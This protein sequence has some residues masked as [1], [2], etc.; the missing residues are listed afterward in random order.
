MPFASQLAGGQGSG[1]STTTTTPDETTDSTPVDPLSDIADRFAEGCGPNDS[2]VCEE[3]SDRTGNETLAGAAEWL[4]AKP[5]S[6][7]GIILVCLVINRLLRRVAGRY[8]GRMVNPGARV[9]RA[10]PDFLHATGVT[11]LRAESRAKTLTIVAKSLV[12]VV[13]WVSA[14][15]S[16]LAMFDIN[17]GP[18]LAGAGVAGVALGFG[19]QSLVRDFLSGTFMI[20]EDQFGVGDV[21]EIA[22]VTG[23]Q[24]AVTGTVEGVTLR[25]TRLRGE[26]GTVWHIPNGEIR[27]VGNKSKEWARAILDVDIAPNADLHRAEEVIRKEADEVADDDEWSDAVLAPPELWG[28]EAV[29]ATATTIRL[30]VKV[31]PSA[32]WGLMRELRARLKD[33]L[34]REGLALAPPAPVPPPA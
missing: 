22:G 1:G 20:I 16:I 10:T 12:S 28:V 14:M 2:W 30:V 7:V 29:S 8:V 11:N 33:A 18:L 5:L 21:V 27:R 23:T 9:R 34:E 32:Q 19:A 13:V 4:V 24:N 3:V 6:V 25:S 26:D 17:L 31:V 15:F